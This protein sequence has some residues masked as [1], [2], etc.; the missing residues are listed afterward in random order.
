MIM[1]PT[2][3]TMDYHKWPTP[4]HCHQCNQPL[5]LSPPKMMINESSTLFYQSTHGWSLRM[6]LSW[7]IT[8]W[9]IEQSLTID[10]WLIAIVN[11]SY[12]IVIINQPLS[13]TIPN[14][15]F[16]MVAHPVGSSRNELHFCLAEESA[17]ALLATSIA[18]RP[19]W[20]H[21][22]ADVDGEI[23]KVTIFRGGSA[24]LQLGF[25]MEA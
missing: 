25:G 8:Y 11:L 10:N 19:T 24:R 23:G 1:I 6:W 20:D 4:N 9:I 5:S 16:T 17:L 2:I 13:W 14:H 18:S 12:I 21:Q 7:L 22:V 15:W 3:P